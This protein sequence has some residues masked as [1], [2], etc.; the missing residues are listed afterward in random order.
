MYLVCHV[1]Y[2]ACDATWQSRRIHVL[3]AVTP[4]PLM[5]MPRL[6]MRTTSPESGMDALLA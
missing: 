4:L 2:R 3:P 1:V 5:L 6:R